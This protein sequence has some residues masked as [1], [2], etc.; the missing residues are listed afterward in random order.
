MNRRAQPWLGTLVDITIFD[1]LDA[2]IVRDCFDQAFQQIAEVHRLMSFHDMLSDVSAINRAAVGAPVTVDAR[3]V[4]V[5]ALAIQLTQISGSIFNIACASC[6]LEW[7]LLPLQQPE[8]PAY[9]AGDCGLVITADG[10]IQKNR[11]IVIDLGGIAKGY[12]VDQAILRLIDCGVSS[13]C[14]NAGGDLRV[15]GS[16]SIPVGIRD[17]E[18][19]TGIARQIDISDAALA[20]SAPYFSARQHNGKVMSALVDGRTG[21]PIIAQRSVSVI[22]PNCMIADA[23]TKIVAATANSDHPLLAQ[24]AATAFIL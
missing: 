10:R 13:A 6:L 14:V 2:A 22:A 17:P 15:I 9:L 7:Q 21:E 11:P 4:A 20:T 18:N 8:V 16:H 12:A 1:A 23:L 3:T 5:I 24:F 19:V